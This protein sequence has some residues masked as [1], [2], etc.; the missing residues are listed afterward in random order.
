MGMVCLDNSNSFKC[1][2]TIPFTNIHE[3][4]R[5]SLAVNA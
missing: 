2:P 5:R 4:Q 1:Q 3:Y